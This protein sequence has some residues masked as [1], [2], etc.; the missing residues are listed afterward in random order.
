MKSKV[1]LIPGSYPIASKEVFNA[2]K[3]ILKPNYE[4][5]ELK[6]ADKEE[7]SSKAG[8]ESKILIGKSLGGRIAVEF[9]LEHKDIDALV[10]LAPAIQADDRYREIEIPVLIIHGLDDD[11]V[12]IENSR[13]IQKYFK[14]CK[15][16]EIPETDHGY[17]GKE[18]EVAKI[19][20]KWI[21]SFIT[22]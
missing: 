14:N 16:V 7:L 8:T 21:A 10:L 22:S 12:P 1:I 5:I 20:A 19:V 11:T 2:I 17:K 4:I 15:L 6:K 18:A 13:E 3:E 9:Y